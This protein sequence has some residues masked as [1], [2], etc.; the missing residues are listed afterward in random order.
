MGNPVKCAD[1]SICEIIAQLTAELAEA[2]ADIESIWKVANDL[3]GDVGMDAYT[4]A[5]AMQAVLVETSARERARTERDIAVH[6][7]SHGY[8]GYPV[9]DIEHSRYPRLPEGSPKAVDGGT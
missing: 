9:D 4:P 3:L 1:L 2:R 7:R 5:E 6:L 8:G